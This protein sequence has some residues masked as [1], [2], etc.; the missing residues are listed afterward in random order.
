[1]I[2][3]AIAVASLLAVGGTILGQLSEVG[4]GIPGLGT[5]ANVTA[6]SAMVYL[7]V[8]TTTKTMPAMQAKSNETIERLVKEFRDENALVRSEREKERERVV[9][10]HAIPLHDH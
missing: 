5:I 4:A 10:H 1:M 7:A 2:D 9:C 3:K 6:S 8:W